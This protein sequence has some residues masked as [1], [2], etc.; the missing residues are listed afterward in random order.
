M[1]DEIIQQLRQHLTE[2]TLLVDTLEFVGDDTPSDSPPDEPTP[3]P[4]PVVGKGEISLTGVVGRPRFQQ[5]RGRSLWTAGLRVGQ[6]A[7]AVWHNIQAWGSPA[8]LARDLVRRGE[9][10]TV[11]GKEKDN[12]YVNADG[13]MVEQT[14]VVVSHFA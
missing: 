5:P 14:V 4:A 13:V 11:V 9:T 12:S 1:Q 7:D 8:E 6:G 10:I 2:M 3:P